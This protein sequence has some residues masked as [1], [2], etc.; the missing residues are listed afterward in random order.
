[1]RGHRACLA[2]FVLASRLHAASPEEFDLSGVPRAPA[3]FDEQLLLDELKYHKPGDLEGA[4]AIQ[5]RLAAFYRSKGDAERAAKAEALAAPPPPVPAAL[6][7]AE[8][9][10]PQG[11]DPR[12]APAPKPPAKGAFAARYYGMDGRL[13][14]TWDFEA[15]GS[16][17]HSMIA[18]G[19][20]TSARSSE[21]GSYELKGGTLILSIARTATA[22]ATPGVGGRSTQLGGGAEEKPEIR[23]VKFKRLPDGC[24]LDGRKLK[25]KSW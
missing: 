8:P 13:L 15:D 5:R 23:R 24:L 22:F 18:S 14:H 9:A 10:P 6:A 7:P 2:V 4:R 20:G 3:S 21:R 1:M 19:A 12:P 25:I 11:G 16:F 17:L